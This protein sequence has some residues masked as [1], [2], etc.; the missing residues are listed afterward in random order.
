MRE[1]VWQALAAMCALGAFLCWNAIEPY[2]V[3]IIC[4]S[5]CVLTGI[6]ALGLGFLLRLGDMQ[7]FAQHMDK[8]PVK[9]KER[10]PP[11]E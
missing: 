1:Y 6:G 4:T 9:K 2:T 11:V 7:N 10:P 8:I 3:R 5:A